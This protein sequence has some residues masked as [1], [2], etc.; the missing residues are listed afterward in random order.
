MTKFVN[1]L[2]SMFIAA[3]LFLALLLLTWEKA[4]PRSLPEGGQ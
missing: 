4:G 3:A 1:A 2:E